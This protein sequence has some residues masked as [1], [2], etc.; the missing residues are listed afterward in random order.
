MR[1]KWIGLCRSNTSRTSNTVPASYG[2]SELRIV[3][4]RNVV[5]RIA[6]FRNVMTCN[7]I[8]RYSL[9]K[10]RSGPEFQA[11]MLLISLTRLTIKHT[12]SL[13]IPSKN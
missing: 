1:P 8:V 10:Y 7:V 11:T 3:M 5:V 4:I 12:A 6:V 9:D 2:S 13:A